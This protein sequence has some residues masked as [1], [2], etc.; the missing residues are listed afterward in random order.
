MSRVLQDGEA[1]VRDRP[2]DD[3]RAQHTGLVQD[4]HIQHL[5][6]AHQQES[7]HLPAEAA[8]TDGRTELMIFDRA[9]YT[10]DRVRPA[11][12]SFCSRQGSR[13]DSAIQFPM[14]PRAPA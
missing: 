9:H 1:V 11:V 6:D 2:E 8:E 4:M 3:R 10:G 12:K 13:P 5:G 7:Q 14:R